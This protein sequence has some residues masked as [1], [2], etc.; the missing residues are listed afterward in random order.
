MATPAKL[1][2]VIDAARTRTSQGRDEKFMLVLPGFCN[3]V[4]RQVN[5]IRGAADGSKRLMNHRGAQS[6]DKPAEDNHTQ[7]LHRGRGGR[8][9][10]QSTT[11]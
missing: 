1:Y 4:F 8:H 5:S 10:D 2:A 11:T 3:W 9:K 6:S 7:E